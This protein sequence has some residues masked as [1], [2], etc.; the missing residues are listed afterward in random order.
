MAIFY[1]YKADMSVG[2]YWNFLTNNGRS[3]QFYGFLNKVMSVNLCSPG[4]DK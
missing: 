1:F 3:T 4:G 2:F